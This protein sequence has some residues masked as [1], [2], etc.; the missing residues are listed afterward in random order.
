MGHDPHRLD[1]D[2]CEF[3]TKKIWD[4]A[5][6]DDEADVGYTTVDD[7]HWVCDECFDDF[8]SRR[9]TVGS[10]PDPARQP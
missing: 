10:H 5:S 6:G 9:W 7:Y 1:H 4:R 8:N 3:C 2:H